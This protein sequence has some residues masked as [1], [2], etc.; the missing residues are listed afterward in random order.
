MEP[1]FSQTR[2]VY[3]VALKLDVERRGG[4]SGTLKAL[5]VLH[6][7]D[8]LDAEFALGGK[9]PLKVIA[10]AEEARGGALAG[11]LGLPAD[12]P[13]TATATSGTIAPLAAQGAWNPKGGY[14]GGRLLLTISR[15]TAPFAERFGREVRFGLAGR[16]ATGFYSGGHPAGAVS[17]A[18]TLYRLNKN[19]HLS[20]K[21]LFS[22]NLRTSLSRNRNWRPLVAAQARSSAWRKPPLAS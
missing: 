7:G 13:F 9:G 12:Q 2:G 1:A 19:N 11:A 4:Q 22:A 16:K 6:P 5:S 18:P 8:H 17:T 20:Q 15:L 21:R 3:D 14:A 10:D